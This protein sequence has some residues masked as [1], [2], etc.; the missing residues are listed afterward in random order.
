MHH[1]RRRAQARARES[2]RALVSGYGLTV[3]IAI[4]SGLRI[5]TFVVSDASVFYFYFFV[6]FVSIDQTNGCICRQY[7]NQHSVAILRNVVLSRVLCFCEYSIIIFN[8]QLAIVLANYRVVLAV[9]IHDCQFSIV[10][11]N[12]QLS[13]MI[14]N[15][16][17][18][19]INYACQLSIIIVNCQLCFSIVN[20]AFRLS[21]MLVNYQLS[22]S[23]INCNLQLS[24]RTLRATLRQLQGDSTR[25][26][27]LLIHCRELLF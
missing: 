11:V 12:C 6:F 27:T 21:I 20:Y 9:V 22:L 8:W 24:I 19:I 13:I 1:L 3:L 4:P 14:V 5:N 17:L 26:I 10:L 7:C 23:T 18:S 15:S 16:Q 25:D 2:R